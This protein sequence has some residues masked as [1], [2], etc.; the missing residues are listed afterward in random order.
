MSGRTLDD[1]VRSLQQTVASLEQQL[2]VLSRTKLERE[3]VWRKVLAPTTGGFSLLGPPLMW[4]LHD[5]TTGIVWNEVLHGKVPELN[6]QPKT[7]AG[8]APLAQPTY[9]YC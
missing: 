9:S 6:E 8:N 7:P 1:K 2:Q 3:W 4:E 5:Q